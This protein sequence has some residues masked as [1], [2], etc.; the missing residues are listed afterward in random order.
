MGKTEEFQAMKIETD[1]NIIKKLS[2]EK[3]E[4]NWNFRA[5]LKRYNAS[6]EEIDKMVC[7]LYETVSAQIDCTTC[8]NCCRKV[9]PILNHKDIRRLSAAIGITERQAGNYE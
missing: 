4:E 9:H 8:A 5:F 3:D 2:Q 7:G 1:L 6:L